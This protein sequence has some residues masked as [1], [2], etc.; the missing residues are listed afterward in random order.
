MDVQGQMSNL[1]EFL[2]CR[3]AYDISKKKKIEKPKIKII[4][5]IEEN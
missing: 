3:T 2:K 5:K 4:R 1:N